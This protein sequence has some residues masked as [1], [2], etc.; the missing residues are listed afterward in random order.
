MDDTSSSFMDV[1]NEEVQSAYAVA[2]KIVGSKYHC[3]LAERVD[4]SV[5]DDAENIVFT[6]R[7][8]MHAKA[9]ELRREW[10]R[11]QHRC[12]QYAEK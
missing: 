3:R 4:V 9:P 7:T 11:F 2:Q 1:P 12:R 5:P 8:A 6:S 10:R